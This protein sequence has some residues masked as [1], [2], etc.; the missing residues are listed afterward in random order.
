[1]AHV[2]AIMALGKVDPYYVWAEATD[3]AG[4]PLAANGLPVLIEASSHTEARKL[5]RAISNPGTIEVPSVLAGCSGFTARIPRAVAPAL[6]AKL[7]AAGVRWELGLPFASPGPEFLPRS[8]SGEAPAP[9]QVVGFIDY[10]CAFAHR[11]FRVEAPGQP[12]GSRVF[13]LWDQGG[14]WKE[15]VKPAAQSGLGLQPPSWRLPRGFSYGAEVRRYLRLPPVAVPGQPAASAKGK[16]AEHFIDEYIRQ[17][18]HDGVVDEPACYRYSGYPA[19]DGPIAHGTHV[20]DVAT[21]RPDPLLHPGCPPE[22]APAT[23]DIVF[24]QLP[25][26]FSGMPVSGLLRTY[27]LDAVNYIFGCAKPDQPVTINLSYGGYV[28]PHDGSS[29]L[30]KALDAAIEARRRSGPTDI[31]IAAGNGA[32]SSTHVEAA[33]EGSDAVQF[34]WSNIPG[35]PTDQFT[36]IWLTGADVSQCEVRFTAPGEQ[37]QPGAWVAVGGLGELK[38]GDDVVARVIAPAAVP[39]GEQ[40]R[41]VLVAVNPTVPRGAR[42]AAPYGRWTL[43]VRNCGTQAVQASAWIERDDPVFPTAAGPRQ[44]RFEGPH[45]ASANTLNSLGHGTSTILVGGYVGMSGRQLDYSG[46]GYL[47]KGP[48]APCSVPARINGA[49]ARPDWLAVCEENPALPGIAAAGVFGTERYRLP[50]TSIAS[51]AA[52]RYVVNQRAANPT[53]TGPVTAP[54]QRGDV[55]GEDC[56]ERV[57]N[58]FGP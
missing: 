52:T 48:N 20:M 56:M 33:V 12:I 34:T 1:M 7:D 50:G 11:Q 19:I 16:P 39:Q 18:V 24:V 15:Y 6:F 27:V 4:M 51:A 40:G 28:G 23:Q 58:P 14:N 54:P 21:G 10:G 45:V 32:T 46:R 9:G 47:G 43:E 37:P 2:S 31:V 17:F 49:R 53:A 38:R 5:A 22:A 57:P 35:N 42:A 55:A 41:M 44:A 13:A 25:R 26:H 8:Y 29:I 30:E 36:E 3:Y